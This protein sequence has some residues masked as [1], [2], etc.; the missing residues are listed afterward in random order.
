RT[1]VGS[2]VVGYSTNDHPRWIYNSTNFGT[3]NFD[4]NALPAGYRNTL[5]SFYDLGSYSF[6]WS[7]SINGSYAWY[8][9]LLSSNSSVYRFNLSLAFGYSVR[10]LRT[11]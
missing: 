10:C 5:G 1:A 4:F 2:P 6:L 11:E 9:Y 3:D 8:R 7:S